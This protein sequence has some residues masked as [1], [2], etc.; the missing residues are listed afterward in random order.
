MVCETKLEIIF[1][2]R[3]FCLLIRF[4]IKMKVFIETRVIIKVRAV[5]SDQA[6]FLLNEKYYKNILFRENLLLFK[7][8]Q[9]EW[10][11]HHFILYSF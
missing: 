8:N 5:T 3:K 9:K 1:L 7:S 11:K 10:K 6:S 2:M 4:C